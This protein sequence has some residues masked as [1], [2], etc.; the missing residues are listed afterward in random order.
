MVK[1][2][3]TSLS[4]EDEHTGKIHGIVLYPR[5]MDTFNCVLLGDPSV[6]KGCLMRSYA[7]RC[8]DAPRHSHTP[9]L[10]KVVV[11]V[12]NRKVTLQLMHIRIRAVCGSLQNIKDFFPSTDLFF[13]CFSVVDQLS[14]E[15]VYSQ[16]YKELQLQYP[17]TPTLLVGMK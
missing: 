13:I 12:D 11:E 2:T 15:H 10:T 17:H 9:L 16:W 6:G 14:Y 5:E 7:E 8:N 1:I 3:G 4:L